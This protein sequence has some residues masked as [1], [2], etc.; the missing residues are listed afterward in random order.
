MQTVKRRVGQA[1]VVD[2]DATTD[3][4]SGINDDGIHTEASLGPLSFRDAVLRK[5]SKAAREALAG[6]GRADNQ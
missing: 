2:T 5:L 4:R 3:Q 6:V 1:A